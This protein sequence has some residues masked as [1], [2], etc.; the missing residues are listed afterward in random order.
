MQ[1]E[2]NLR[3][4]KMEAKKNFKKINLKIWQLRQRHQIINND[5]RKRKKYISYVFR[6]IEAKWQPV[7]S[8]TRLVLL[9]VRIRT[10]IPSN[11]GSTGWRKGRDSGSCR[12]SASRVG[13]RAWRSSSGL[14]TGR[15]SKIDTWEMRETERW[16]AQG[17]KRKRQGGASPLFEEGW[18]WNSTDSIM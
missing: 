6:G 4:W 15:G 9:L 13:I 3:D 12:Y 11:W 5:K 1:W 16:K 18:Q 8:L 2:K 10:G 17:E 7:Q 14:K